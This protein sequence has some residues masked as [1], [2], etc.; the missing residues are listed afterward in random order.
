MQ[1]KELYTYDNTFIFPWSPHE[2]NNGP[3]PWAKYQIS[4]S[5]QYGQGLS[6]L[7]PKGP[8]VFEKCVYL[9]TVPKGNIS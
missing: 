6:A 7:V 1:L 4:T 9:Q 2:L 5:F 8:E 3:E